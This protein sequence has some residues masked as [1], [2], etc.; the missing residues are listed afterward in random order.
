MRICILYFSS[1]HNK[2]SCLF[3]D[4]KDITSLMIAF[5][6]N[7]ELHEYLSFI[8]KFLNI[9][10]MYLRYSNFTFSVYLSIYF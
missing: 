1:K 9:I 5:A 7:S 2:Y 4:G 8:L 10:G 3:L 6:W